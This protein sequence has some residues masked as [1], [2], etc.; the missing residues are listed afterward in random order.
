MNG[1]SVILTFHGG[2]KIKNN[3]LGDFP[4]GSVVKTLPSTAGDVSSIPGLGAWIPCALWPKK[5]K[6][7]NIVRN[8]IKI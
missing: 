6:T 1:E 2:G 4:G 7:N 5:Y 3:D 8:S